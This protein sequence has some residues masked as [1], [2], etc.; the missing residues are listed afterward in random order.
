[1][2]TSGV[3]PVTLIF[4]ERIYSVEAIQKATY[5]YMNLFTPDLSLANGQIHCLLNPSKELSLETFENH[6]DDFKKEVL[7]QHLR[8]KIRAETESVRNLIIGIAF[9]N[10]SLH[11]DE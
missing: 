3:T 7:D 5:R 9:S 10:T 6:I 2:A 4:D 8:L 11:S 1:M